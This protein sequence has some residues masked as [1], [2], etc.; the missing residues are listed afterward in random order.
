MI[1]PSE[2]FSH[3]Q[4]W[5]VTNGLLINL[6]KTKELVQHRPHPSKLNLPK[7]LRSVEHVQ[8]AELL[9]VIFQ[10]SFSYVNHVNAILKVC[11]QC[12]F[13]LKQLRDQGMP[14]GQLHTIYA[15]ILSCLTYAIRPFLSVD[16]K[17][18]IDAFLKKSFRY[19]F[20]K[21]IFEIQTTADS[22]VYKLFNNINDLNH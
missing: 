4:T 6:D 17:Q 7:S 2:E 1:V 3:I 9:G 8:T 20:S 19:G 21:Q 16:I 18:T 10:S 14:L 22:A 11:S 12:I 15:I 5:T 13:L